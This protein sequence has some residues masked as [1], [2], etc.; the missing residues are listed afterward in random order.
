MA[1]GLG[2]LALDCLD[3]FGKRG[4]AADVAALM[5]TIIV[6]CSV[7]Q[8]VIHRVWTHLG[9]LPVSIGDHFGMHRR[10]LS[11]CGGKADQWV[12]TATVRR[13]GFPADVGESITPP[14]SK[15][16]G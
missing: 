4:T 10:F 1:C 7:V 14:Q 9:A 2:L 16:S 6:A 5:V 11:S 15:R 13:L 3:G 12:T 8:D